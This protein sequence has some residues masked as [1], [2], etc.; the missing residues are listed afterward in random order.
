METIAAFRAIVQVLF[1]TNLLLLL[2]SWR[3]NWLGPK[4]AAR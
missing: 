3:Y 1:G 4:T 2:V